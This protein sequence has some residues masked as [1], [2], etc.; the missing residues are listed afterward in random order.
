MLARR[1]PVVTHA[2]QADARWQG[3]YERGAR[4][5]EKQPGHPEENER[6]WGSDVLRQ[7]GQPVFVTEDYGIHH[8]LTSTTFSRYIS[9]PSVH[10]Q[11]NRSNWETV[12]SWIIHSPGS[13]GGACQ[14]PVPGAAV[15]DRRENLCNRDL[16]ASTTQR[17]R[18]STPVAHDFCLGDD[19]VLRSIHIGHIAP[20]QACPGQSSRVCCYLRY[21]YRKYASEREH[22]GTSNGVDFDGGTIWSTFNLHLP[23]NSLL[24]LAFIHSRPSIFRTGAT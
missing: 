17:L 1:A 12:H 16:P 14:C 6:L 8:A 24:T 18:G 5:G 2:Q 22:C 15:W 4:E 19:S 21:G 9:I 20:S 11:S 13:T 3:P 7:V 23:R 10:L